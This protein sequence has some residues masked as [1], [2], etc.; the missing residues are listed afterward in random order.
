MDVNGS[1][2]H[3]LLGPA[4]WGSCTDEDGDPLGTLWATGAAAPVVWTDADEVALPASVFRFPAARGDAPPAL[5]D[6]RG[7][8]RDR[9]GNW[10]WIGPG[11]RGVL[12]GSAGDG[13]VSQ[14]WPGHGECPPPPAA[15]GAFGPPAD[16]PPPA[17]A[18]PLR[19]AAVTEDHRLVV[20]TLAPG[21]L[22]VF[23]L[24]TGGP[25]AVHVWPAGVPFAPWDIAPRP[26]GGVF[27]LDRDARAVWELDRRLQ[28]VAPPPG[29]APPGAFGPG[30]G[31]PA[32]PP[33][34]VTV[35]LDA[36]AVEAVPDGGFL[37]LYRGTARSL[38]RLFRDGAPV[39]PLAPVADVAQGLD[40]VAHDF[41]LAGGVLYVADRAGNQSYAF[42]L[43]PGPAL[44]LVTRFF[45]MRRFGGKGLVAAGDTVYYDV[46]DELWAPLVCQPR[47]GYAESGTLVTPGVDGGEPACVWHRLL[48]DAWLPPGTGLHV[49]SRAAD[50]ADALPAMPWQPE[51][52]PLARPDGPE[53]PFAATGAYTTTELLFQRAVGR[54][55]Q[56]RLELYGDG[57]ARTAGVARPSP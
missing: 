27:V 43:A 36:I 38:V 28:L 55:L 23:D 19:G 52:D 51:P 24:L 10:Y 56:V 20:G 8:G 17:P 33:A 47:A 2:F 1:R 40:V 15:P 32:P 57:R 4:D 54:H 37:V 3:L 11:A 7:A 48:V 13:S 9:Y 6:R 21:G 18:Q 35:G 42:T 29:V 34:P 49:W 46:G 39:G 30:A 22:L 53:V 44:T 41:A 50:E 14:F 12:V 26:G 45:P 5:S 16:A 31:A 25:P